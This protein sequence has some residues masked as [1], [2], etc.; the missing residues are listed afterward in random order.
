VF[1]MLTPNGREATSLQVAFTNLY[2]DFEEIFN[3]II[4]KLNFSEALFALQPFSY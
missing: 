3:N 1:G 4:L 2:S